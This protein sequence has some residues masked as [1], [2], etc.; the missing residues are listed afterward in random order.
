MIKTSLQAFHNKES[1]KQKYVSRM[2]SH[3]AA[4]EL[5]RGEGW[6]GKKGCAV[7]C[8]LN[9]YNHKCYQD[10]LGLPEWLARLE[11]TLFEGMSLEKSKTFPLEFLEAI[12][13]GANLDKT[14]HK[15]CIY[16][17]QDCKKNVE[18][19]YDYVIEAIDSVIGYHQKSIVGFESESAAWSAESAARS[20]ESA[21]SAAR[22]AASAAWSA[23]SAAWSAE[24]AESAARSAESAE[25]A[26]WSAESAA[27]SARSARSAWSA[28]RSAAESARSAAWSAES[29]ESAEL[30][31]WSAVFDRYADKLLELFKEIDNE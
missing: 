17:L 9:R 26:A 21:E 14:F 31:A 19:K 12:P 30:A 24:S 27:W 7:G 4:D 6:T 28:A 10:E 20:A 15:F 3:I 23:E 22:S 11:D 5:I 8:T 16:V 29:A 18:L 2:K 25:S 1:E 13:V